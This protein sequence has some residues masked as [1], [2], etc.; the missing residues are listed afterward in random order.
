MIAA[1]P[2][3]SIVNIDLRSRTFRDVETVSSTIIQELNTWYNKLFKLLPEIVKAKLNILDAELEVT[4]QRA[5]N[6][7]AECLQEVCD[8]L[9]KSLPEWSWLNGENIPTPILCI[10][11]ANRLQALSRGNIVLHDF[12]A[13]VVLNTKQMNRFHVVMAS[14]DSFFHWW[15]SHRRFVFSWAPI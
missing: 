13:W 5:K 1:F 12:L 2:D 6:R 14:S 11:E 10:D 7:P 4:F 9:S 8:A 15:I 3:R